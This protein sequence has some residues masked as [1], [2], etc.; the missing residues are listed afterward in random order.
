MSNKIDIY[1]LI[2]DLI[3]GRL[4][5][6][7]ARRLKKL[8]DEDPALQQI[9]DMATRLRAEGQHIGWSDIRGAVH[10]LLDRQLRQHKSRQGN[11]R[12]AFLTFDSSL[13]PLPEGIRPA[14][15]SER[16]LK[17]QIEDDV[18]EI[19]LYP[20]SLNSYEVI[21]QLPDTFADTGLSV[22]IRCGNRMI[23]GDI[24]EFGVFHFDRVPTGPC[25][26]VISSGKK[27]EIE[28]DLEI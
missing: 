17:F 18:L 16:R 9:M 5:G 6:T 13:L 23:A 7:E 26:I 22:A 25:S 14:T 11:L 27:A 19:G 28:V 1:R 15:V 4:S 10:D 21:G 20:L 8:I 3:E 24:G 12:K 2:I